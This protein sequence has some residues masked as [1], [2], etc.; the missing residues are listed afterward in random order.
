MTDQ[1]SPHGLPFHRQ[2]TS[3]GLHDKSSGG[4][5]SKYLRQCT[6]CV[7]LLELGLDV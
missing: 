4:V 1:E 7:A 3:K 6:A 5:L 2:G